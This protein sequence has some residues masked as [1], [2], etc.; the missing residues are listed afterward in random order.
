MDLYLGYKGKLSTWNMKTYD[1]AVDYGR[2]CLKGHYY[3]RVCVSNS[4]E[5]GRNDGERT[6]FVDVFKYCV[7]HLAIIKRLIAPIC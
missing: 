4:E 1:A 7:C 6:F 2:P 5:G 3:S